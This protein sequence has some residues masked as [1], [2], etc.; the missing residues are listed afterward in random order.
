MAYDLEEQ[1]Q[2]DELKAWWKQNGKMLS[3]LVVDCASGLCY[4]SRL[5][6]LPK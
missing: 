4:V 6:L 2:I 1:E 5:E 3:T